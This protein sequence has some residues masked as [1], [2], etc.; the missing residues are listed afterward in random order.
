[1]NMKRLLAAASSGDGPPE[2]YLP[3]RREPALMN[4]TPDY[5]PSR[6][7][8]S[9][10]SETYAAAIDTF[11]MLERELEAAKAEIQELRGKIHFL[12]MQCAE[13]KSD[14]ETL[15]I[16]LEDVRTKYGELRGRVLS[17][18]SMMVDMLREEMRDDRASEAGEQISAQ[19]LKPPEP[20]PAAT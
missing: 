2:Q 16:Q 20:P 10:M 9:R 11:K 19:D 4:P 3:K 17:A 8:V 6:P 15:G 18:S 5:H 1:M 7:A 13:L 14:K 12:D